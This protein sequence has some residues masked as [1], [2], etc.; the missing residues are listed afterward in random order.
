VTK[1]VISKLQNEGATV[2]RQGYITRANNTY[3]VQFTNSIAVRPVIKIPKEEF[4]QLYD[5]E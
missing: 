3:Y 1:F 4:D 2:D 5:G